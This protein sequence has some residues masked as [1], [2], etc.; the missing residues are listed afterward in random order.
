MVQQ[1]CAIPFRGDD[2]VLAVAP[3][4]HAVGFGVVANATLHAGA[5]LVTIP[6]FD[7]EQFLELIERYRVTATT[8]VPPIVLALAKHPAVDGADLRSLASSAAAPPRSAPPC[9]RPPPTASA[10][11]CCR[12]GA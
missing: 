8:V 1:E 10:A 6:R 7:V 2:R 12:A 3:F 11:P 9:S 4:F 5:T